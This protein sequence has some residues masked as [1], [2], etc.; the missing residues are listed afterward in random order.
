MHRPRQAPPPGD[1]P[2]WVSI[3][4]HLLAR[5]P[6]QRHAAVAVL[7]AT[8]AAVAADRRTRDA[9]AS[10]AVAPGGVEPAPRPCGRPST[11]ITVTSVS[12]EGRCQRRRKPMP[13]HHEQPPCL[14]REGDLRP[15]GSSGTVRPASRAVNGARLKLARGLGACTGLAAWA[16]S[17]ARCTVRSAA[18][19]CG[20]HVRRGGL[21]TVC[22][23]LTG[24]VGLALG[25]LTRVGSVAR[26]GVS[27]FGG[28]A[29][30]RRFAGRRG[31]SRRRL[32]RPAA[33]TRRRTARPRLPLPRSTARR[34]ARRAARVAA[35]RPAGAAATGAEPRR[36]RRATTAG[37]A[38]AAAARRAASLHGHRRRS[39]RGASCVADD[40][41]AAARRRRRRGSRPADRA[42]A[43]KPP[44]QRGD[45][46]RAA[47][48]AAGRARAAGRRT[49]C[50]G[51]AALSPRLGVT[52]S[53]SA[54][55]R[56]CSATASR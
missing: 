34:P 36:R 19:A 31:R 47:A 26:G 39:R 21:A 53:T 6:L 28:L 18:P 51:R 35:G 4:R 43:A 17:R 11:I 54:S 56:R 22:A 7:P 38:G 29:A 49:R 10:V 24:C 55:A 5:A 50:R 27:T 42:F 32:R 37:A 48:A 41:G 8:A 2:A 16:A 46:A 12:G 40:R 9:P 23:A 30:L 52:G 20:D 44:P 14:A 45:R 25:S 3:R 15:K 33:P 13:E 1:V